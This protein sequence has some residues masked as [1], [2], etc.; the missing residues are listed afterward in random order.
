MR[1]TPKLT[2]LFVLVP[3]IPLLVVALVIYESSK[4]AIIH[5]TINH[6]RSTNM[7]KE[8]ELKRWIENGKTDLLNL[9]SRPTFKDGIQRYEEHTKLT[10]DLHDE[11]HREIVEDRL[12]PFLGLGGFLELSILRPEDGLTV[13]STDPDQ[14]GTYRD[15]EAYFVQGKRDT[16]L[17]RITYSQSLE[18]PVMLMSTPVRNRK[19]DLVA[20]LAGRFDLR[21]LSKI[22]TQGRGLYETED[23]YVVNT[24]NFFVTEPRFGNDYALKKTV[25]TE[26]VNAALRGED[27]TGFYKDYRGI[28]VIGAYNWVSEYGLALVVEI[29]QREAFA[30][31]VRMRTLVIGIA[32]AMGLIAALVAFGFARTITR[33]VLLLLEGTGEVGRGNL[34][35]RVGTRA[36]D[37][38]GELSRA[39]DHMTERLRTTTVSRDELARERDFSDAVINSLPGVFYLFDTSGYLVRWN[40]NLEK[41][42]KHTAEEMATMSFME[43][44]SKDERDRVKDAIAKGFNS[45]EVAFEADFLRKRGSTIP[46]SMTGVRIVIG[47]KP[48][49]AGVGIDISERRRAEEELKRLNSDLAR[50]N[51]ELEQFAYV[52]SH[53]LQEPLRMVSSYTQ[54]LARRY[55][56]KLD[57]DA[58]DF[59]GFAV[60]GAT[61]MQQ[62]IQ[63]LL[64]YS[65]V[66]TRGRE[67]EPVDS[68]DAFREALGNLEF[69]I[70]ETGAEVLADGLPSVLADRTQLVQ[71]FQN[72]VGNAIKFRKPDSAPRVQVSAVKDPSGL[73]L[74]DQTISNWIFSIRDN[75][76]GIDSKYFERLFIIFQR[77]HTQNQYPGTGIGLALCKRIVERHGGKIWVESNPGE[78]STFHF[79]LRAP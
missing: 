13:F 34:D 60:D 12:K 9:A 18:Q 33:P 35:T 72:L 53:D 56:D 21:E 38:I 62:L 49:L 37:E 73:H 10:Q 39:F 7:L 19:G 26:G 54:L 50:S 70:E 46:Y 42:T 75:G 41:L 6:L 30:P 68:G 58:R 69:L 36:K 1:L 63:D 2:M 43:F 15:D 14:E 3:I 79:T 47:D 52:A 66:T 71:L 76:I 31:A 78:G 77:L 32:L 16:Y 4:S 64:A 20:V 51:R 55:K 40:L 8:A 27:G 67:A 17:Q 11:I 74:A 22:I 25:Q 28:P 65:R 23:P 48:L 5:E 59:I 44:F 57:D 45:G 61:R 29:D 24:F